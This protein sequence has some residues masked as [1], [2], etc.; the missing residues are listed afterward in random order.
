MQAIS[1]VCFVHSKTV[2]YVCP[3]FFLVKPEPVIQKAAVTQIL[4]A[5]LATPFECW[6]ELSSDRL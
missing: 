4:S 3:R 2:A 5:G 6:P 1:V